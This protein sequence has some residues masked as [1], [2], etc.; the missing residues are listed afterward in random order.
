V[1]QTVA[2]P[3]PGLPPGP[4]GSGPPP[5]FHLQISYPDLGADEESCR[6]RSAAEAALTAELVSDQPVDGKGGGG[7]GGGGGATASALLAS[8]HK[9]LV[10]L[11]FEP[12]R[13]LAARARLA[14]VRRGGGSWAVDVDLTV[15]RG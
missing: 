9:L 14:A 3:L 10:N 8:A 5:P 7:G 1:E 12:R 11:A 13:A 15:S 4:P 6:I 2:I